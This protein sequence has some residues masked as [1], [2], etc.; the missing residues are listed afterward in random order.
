MKKPM[1]FR[2]MA[3]N[4]RL[5]TAEQHAD[6][7]VNEVFALQVAELF[8]D[9]AE[10]KQRPRWL[11]GECPGNTKQRLQELVKQNQAIHE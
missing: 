6:F 4:T 7:L 10:N 3:W 8:F 5:R 9:A 2:N 11:P 1:F